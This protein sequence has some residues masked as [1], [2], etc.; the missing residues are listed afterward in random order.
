MKRKW[1]KII[2]WSAGGTLITMILLTVLAGSV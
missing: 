2:I 1:K